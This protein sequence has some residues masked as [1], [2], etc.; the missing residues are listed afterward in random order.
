MKNIYSTI[1]TLTVLICFGLACQNN[2]LSKLTKKYTCTIAGEPE[3]VTSEDFYNRAVK[4][5]KLFSG[6]DATSL[7]DCAFAAL[8][9]AIQL[10]PNNDKALFL[11]GFGYKQRKNIPSAMADFGKVVE[12]NPKYHEAYYQRSKIHAEERDYQK[13]IQDITNAI[14]SAPK[15]Y[16]LLEGYYFERGDYYFLSSQFEKALS[17]LDEAIRYY[18]HSETY[19]KKRAEIYRKLGKNDLA[20]SDELTAEHWNTTNTPANSNTQTTKNLPKSV[21]VGVLNGKAVNLVQPVYPPAAKAVKAK[22]AVNV[23]VTIDENGNVIS[24]TAVSGHPLLRSAAETAAKASKFA[25]TMLSGQKVKV[26]G[27]IVYNF[28]GE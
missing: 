6:D 16:F 22:G 9:E 21:S 8:D 2:P 25:P 26:T 15:D 12:I 5:I 4:H 17:D 18:P 23:Q 14:D 20:E 13:A 24:A 19:L 3:P 7:D 1:L 11:R 27:V 10:N 28:V